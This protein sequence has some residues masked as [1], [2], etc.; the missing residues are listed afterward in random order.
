MCVLGFVATCYKECPDGGNFHSQA[1]SLLCH[2]SFSTT[3]QNKPDVLYGMSRA[4]RA[5][6]F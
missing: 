2:T 3:D 6:V 5:A 1:C 4:N